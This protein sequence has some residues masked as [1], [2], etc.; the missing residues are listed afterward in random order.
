MLSEALGLPQVSSGDIFR[1]NL[2]NETPLGRWPRQYMDK[3]EL[4][5]DDVTINMVMD[6]L[7]RTTIAPAC[8]PGWLPTHAGQADALDEA[9]KSRGP[10]SASCRCSKWRRGVDQ[11]AGRPPRLP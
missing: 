4:V 5:P 8:H 10:A 3:G 11:P 1:E 2:K 6:R 9:L 7:G